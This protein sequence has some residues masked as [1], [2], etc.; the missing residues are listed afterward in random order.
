MI[1]AVDWNS[2]LAN[3]IGFICQCTGLHP[4]RFSTWDPDLWT[5][6]LGLQMRMCRD[7]FNEWMWQEPM[8]QALAPP[9]PGA[10]RGMAELAKRGEVWIV[11]STA[12][13]A[14]VAP[15]LRKNGIYPDRIILTSDKGSVEWDILI[16]DNPLTLDALTLA[17]RNVLRH[18]VP[19][20]ECL[21]N[22]VRGVRWQ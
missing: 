13:P 12:C 9:Y 1:I 4:S 20:N 22:Q 5:P 10:A 16:D 7:R 19:W 3:N 2:T 8:L 6:A 11:T 18:I 14:L 15:W 21:A 17:S